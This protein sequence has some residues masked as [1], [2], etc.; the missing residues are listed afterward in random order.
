MPA[1]SDYGLT[2]DDA[3]L[4][5]FMQTHHLNRRKGG[6]HFDFG[7]PVREI[8]GALHKLTGLDLDDAN[9]FQMHLSDDPRRQVLQRRIYTR[10]A[11]RW[12]EWWETNWQTLTKDAAYQKVN[13]PVTKELVQ[14]QPSTMKVSKSA[15][16]GDQTSGAVISPPIEKGQYVWHAYDLDTGFVPQWPK[17][18]PKDAAGSDPKKLKDWAAENGVDLVCVTQRA[19]GRHGDIP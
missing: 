9:L 4:S 11:Q 7:R 16:I 6:A 3:V 8:I 18:M 12:Q 10:Q 15:Q 5:E 1:C 19:P 13:L 14:P 17:G 2:V